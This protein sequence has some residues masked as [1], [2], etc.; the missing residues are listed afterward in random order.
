MRISLGEQVPENEQISLSFNF[1]YMARKMREPIVEYFAL[2]V[3]K[4]PGQFGPEDATTVLDEIW[5]K[6]PLG[7]NN[8]AQTVRTTVQIAQWRVVV[9]IYLTPLVK[10]LRKPL[11]GCATT[12]PSTSRPNRNACSTP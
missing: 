7:S 11:V 2:L 9:T 6:K 1:R 10:K 12:S 4:P 8:E 5:S 3:T